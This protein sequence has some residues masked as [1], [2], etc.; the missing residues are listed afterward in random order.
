MT[1]R[2]KLSS[3]ARAI[4]ERADRR[5]RKKY[6]QLLYKNKQI[7]VIKTSVGREIS[8]FVWEAMMHYYNGEQIDH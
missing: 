1:Q 6:N 4:V 3:S 2:A 5:Y 7:N 8:S